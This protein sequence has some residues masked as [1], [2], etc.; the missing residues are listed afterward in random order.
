MAQ[1]RLMSRSCGVPRLRHVG[2]RTDT[3]SSATRRP[4]HETR[5]RRGRPS[6]TACLPAIAGL[7]AIAVASCWSGTALARVTCCMF[8]IRRVSTTLVFLNQCCVGGGLVREQCALMRRRGASRGSFDPFRLRATAFA[9]AAG[10]VVRARRGLSGG[11]GEYMAMRH[12]TNR[13]AR[14]SPCLKAWGACARFADSKQ[15]L[16]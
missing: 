13:D 5:L 15:L 6:A 8:L 4:Q 2:L 16:A 11:A 3:G 12:I 7:S 10:F 9:F 1:S 14:S